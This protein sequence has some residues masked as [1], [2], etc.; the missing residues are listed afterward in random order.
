M[1]RGL[2]ALLLAVFLAAPMAFADVRDKGLESVSVLGSW[3]FKSW[4]Y[5]DCEFGGVA[6]LMAGEEPGVMACEL[7]ARQSCTLPDRRWVVRQSCVARR[8]GNQ[9]AIHS[10]IEEFIEGEPTA[11]YWPDHFILTL[12]E[13][14][15]M[16]GSL[17]SHG[18]HPSEFRRNIEGI[19]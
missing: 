1:R 2:A 9:V 4:T 19:S 13:P 17:I 7:I 16:T 3:T 11:N 8:T 12:R 14:D 15:R 6:R 18:V 10:T 5:D